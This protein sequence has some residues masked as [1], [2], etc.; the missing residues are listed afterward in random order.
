[1]ALFASNMVPEWLLNVLISRTAFFFPGLMTGFALLIEAK[2]R[3][4]EL[5]M[6][7]LPKALESAWRI[8]TGKARGLAGLKTAGD[9]GVGSILVSLPLLLFVMGL[10]FFLVANGCGYEHDDGYLPERPPAPFWIS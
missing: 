8:G 7:V 4:G 5:A 3:R 1:M 2:H 6:Y 9:K 10:M